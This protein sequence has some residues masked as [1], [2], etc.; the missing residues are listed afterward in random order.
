M[1]VIHTLWNPPIKIIDWFIHSCACNKA[2]L[3]ETEVTTL[4]GKLQVS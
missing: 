2:I 1:L 3:H 4:K